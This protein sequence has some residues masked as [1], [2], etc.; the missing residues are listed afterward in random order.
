MMA[1]LKYVNESSEEFPIETQ[2]GALQNSFSDLVQS[3]DNLD[4][5]YCVQPNLQMK[6]QLDELWQLEL[7]NRESIAN[8]QAAI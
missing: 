8:Q 5:T 7:K 4:S 3:I 2:I 1:T 6:R